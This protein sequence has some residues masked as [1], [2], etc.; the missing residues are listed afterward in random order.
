[1]LRLVD[2]KESLKSSSSGRAQ[3]ENSLFHFHSILLIYCKGIDKFLLLWLALHFWL[4]FNFTQIALQQTCVTLE[5][6]E[7]FHYI[8]L[9]KYANV[10]KQVTFWF[11]QSTAQWI[12]QFF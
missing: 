8:I 6:Y 1:M 10:S 7:I 3:H 12:I 11:A 5:I 4:A 9:Q 2:P